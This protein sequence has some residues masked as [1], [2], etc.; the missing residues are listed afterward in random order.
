MTA[1]DDP[2]GFDAGSA[3]PPTARVPG[4]RTL[5]HRVRG[6]LA[7]GRP[8]VVVQGAPRLGRGVLLEA[9]PGARIVLGD[10]CVLLDGCRLHARAGELR[11]GAGAVLGERCTL[12]AHER[13]ELGAGCRLGDG[14]VATDLAP[15]HADVEVP[16]RHQGVRTAPVRIGD[17]ARVGPGAVLEAGAVVPAGDSVGAHR[18]LGGG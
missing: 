1:A 15:V 9:A 12:V 7:G 11:I 17:G 5:R 3:V 14:V 8:G 2:G 18:V 13:V 4:R 6:L 16:I 10:G